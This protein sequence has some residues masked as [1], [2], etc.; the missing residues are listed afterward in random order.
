MKK[1]KVLTKDLTDEELD[2]LI[3]RRF[4]DFLENEKDSLEFL[5]KISG[6]IK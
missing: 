3:Y 2:N 5:N 6:R 1:K 4:L